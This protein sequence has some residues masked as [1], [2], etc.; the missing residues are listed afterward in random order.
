MWE[1]MKKPH[2]DEYVQLLFQVPSDQLREF[3]EIFASFGAKEVQPQAKIRL[4][5]E[6]RWITFKKFFESGFGKGPHVDEKNVFKTM[7]SSR[8]NAL[9]KAVQKAIAPCELPENEFDK[10][11]KGIVPCELST[12][13]LERFIKNIII[14][15]RTKKAKESV[16]WEE[17]YPNFNP[18]VALR[19]ARKKEG[20]TQEEL[21]Q[22][23]GI[24]Q[25]HISEMENGKRTIGKEMAKRLSN[26]LKIDYRVFL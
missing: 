18:S 10:F 8:A 2:T 9:R 22:L 14:S 7:L 13:T 6:E 24:S 25:T 1:H 5:T 11:I 26:I 4:L 23:I 12:K 20:L 15:C 3:M 19:G 21:A 17:V 16:P